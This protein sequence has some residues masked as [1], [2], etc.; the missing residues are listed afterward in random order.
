MMG[1]DELIKA[2]CIPKIQPAQDLAE[3]EFH[4][5]DYDLEKAETALHEK[6]YKWAIVKAY[7]AVFHSAKGIMFL[8]GFR[9]KAHF[10]A[11]EFLDFL[12]KKGKLESRY[13][14]DFKACMSARQAADYN[15]DYSGRTA[16]EILEIAE[17]FVERMKKLRKVV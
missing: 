2:N 9:E 3:K 12:S 13:V 5:A 15:Y 1:L 4:E 14:S 7:Y 6:D 17:E 11:G 8:M 16:E 10:A